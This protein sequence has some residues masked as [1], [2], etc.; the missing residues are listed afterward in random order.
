MPQKIFSHCNENKLRS[1]ARNTGFKKTAVMFQ[2]PVWSLTCKCL[3]SMIRWPL[4]SK[5]L[6]NWLQLWKA[7]KIKQYSFLGHVSWL[8]AD[9]LINQRDR[10]TYCLIGSRT[11]FIPLPLGVDNGFVGVTGTSSWTRSENNWCLSTG[12]VSGW[13]ADTQS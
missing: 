8:Y 6:E 2:I 13:P 3:L 12:R 7:W 10:V 9:S 4:D 5:C 11:G 1:A